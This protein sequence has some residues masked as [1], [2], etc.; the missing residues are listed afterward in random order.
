[1]DVCFRV[2]TIPGWWSFLA[3]TASTPAHGLLRLPRPT[4]RAPLHTCRR[5]GATSSDRAGHYL[6]HPPLADTGRAHRS[7]YL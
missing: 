6:L 1:M 5:P 4:L 7:R 3:A 2:L